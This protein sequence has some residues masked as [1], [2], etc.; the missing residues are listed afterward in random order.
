MVEMSSACCRHHGRDIDGAC[1]QLAARV[2]A[3]KAG[4][5]SAD[6]CRGERDIED[7]I[8]SSS[9]GQ[10]RSFRSR[11]RLPR[12]KPRL[13]GDGSTTVGDAGEEH[14]EGGL[15][16]QKSRWKRLALVG[17]TIVLGA[18]VAIVVVARG[19]RRR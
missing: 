8:A 5:G 17:A 18:T 1:G 15:L 16:G 4:I 10:P 11:R 3:S 13:R 19:R 2:V 9:E 12:D 14:G 6:V 7:I